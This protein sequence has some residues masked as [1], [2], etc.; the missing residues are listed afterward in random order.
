MQITPSPR[1][2][3]PDASTP[4][5]QGEQARITFRN[6]VYDLPFPRF[7]FCG[8]ARAVC[9]SAVPGPPF[10]LSQFHKSVS[11]FPHHGKISAAT[12]ESWPV[13]T[14]NSSN[15]PISPRIPSFLP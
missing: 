9:R 1:L 7:Q 4:V 10:R 5:R 8:F 12:W 13:R 14:E 3:N 2:V 11:Q 6:W 15:L